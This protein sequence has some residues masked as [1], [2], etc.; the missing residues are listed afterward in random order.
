VAGFIRIRD[1]EG[2]CD[3]DRYA[4]YVPEHNPPDGE[5]PIEWMLLSNLPVRSFE[6]ACEKVFWYCLR[7]RIEMYC[8]VLKSGFRVGACRSGHAE[9]LTRYLTVMSIVAWRLFMIT[10][11]ARTDPATPCTKLLADHEKRSSIGEV[12]TWIARLGGFL[13]RKGDGT[14]GMIT[15]WRGWKRLTEGWTLTTQ[16]D[17]CW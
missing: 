6:E 17:T 15:L 4:V 12:V 2:L 3:I 13:A 5:E 8:K 7:W 1:R 10:L 9:R 11:V 16:F 14:P